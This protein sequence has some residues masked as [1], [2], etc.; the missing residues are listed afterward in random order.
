M[1]AILPLKCLILYFFR[2]EFDKA[3]SLKLGKL[4]IYKMGKTGYSVHILFH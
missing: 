1:G 2:L 3:R 4:F